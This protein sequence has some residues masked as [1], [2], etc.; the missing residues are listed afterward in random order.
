MKK[1]YDFAVSATEELV[2]EEVQDKG[3]FNY[4]YIFFITLEVQKSSQ[5][6]IFNTD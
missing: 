1:Q 3:T 5:T 2:Q 4:F 6:F